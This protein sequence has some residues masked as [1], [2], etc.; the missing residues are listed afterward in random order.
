MVCQNVPEKNKNLFMDWNK[1][2]GLPSYR[3]KCF[4]ADAKTINSTVD[5]GALDLHSQFRTR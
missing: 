1:T 4:Y 5:N 2:S 3:E